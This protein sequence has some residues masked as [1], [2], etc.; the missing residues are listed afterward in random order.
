MPIPLAPRASCAS[1]IWR[2][3]LRTFG[4]QPPVATS[5]FPGGVERA[6]ERIFSELDDAGVACLAEIRGLGKHDLGSAGR[7]MLASGRE[8]VG[9]HAAAAHAANRNGAPCRAI[10][11]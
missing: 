3:R 5:R 2:H 10:G 11:S 7:A 8:L 4:A 6:L 1:P 9:A